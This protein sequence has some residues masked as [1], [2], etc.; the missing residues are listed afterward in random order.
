[1]TF[2]QTGFQEPQVTHSS[3]HLFNNIFLFIYTE[4][5]ATL[6]LEW[7]GEGDVN[8]APTWHKTK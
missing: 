4:S 7:C 1:M 8:P 6:E 5:E 3:I 2:A